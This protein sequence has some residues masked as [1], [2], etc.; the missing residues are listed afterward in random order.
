MAATSARH[1]APLGED[2]LD[3]AGVM[4]SWRTTPTGKRSTA[5]ES[6]LEGIDDKPLLARINGQWY[7]PVFANQIGRASCRERVSS[8][9]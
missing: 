3:R 6:L 5:K 2:A 9:V 8:P 7:L 1:L 4:K